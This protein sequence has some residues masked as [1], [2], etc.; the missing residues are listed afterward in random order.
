MSMAEVRPK[1]SVV[2]VGTTGVGRY[3]Q[4]SVISLASEAVEKALLDAAVSRSSIDGLISHIGYPRG[5]DYD[6]LATRLGLSVEFAAQPWSH[7]RFGASVLQHAAMA[8]A[9]GLATTV[10]C[11][12]AYRNTP[13]GTVGG[14]NHVYFAEAMR[15]GGGPHA[16]TPHAALNAPVA[17]C[18]MATQRYLHKYGIARE[19]LAA[20]PIAM[21]RHARLNSS[22]L[23]QKTLDET[24]YVAA[25]FIVEP[26]RLL[27]CSVVADGAVAIVLTGD[28]RAADAPH[29]MVRI[30]GMQG[31]A[32]GPNAYIFG[33]PG[34]GINDSK[35][36]DFAPP[37]QGDRV[38]RM[39]GVK[40][41]DIQMLQIYDAFS[42]LVPFTLE[43]F[44]FCAPGTAID[45]LQNGRIELG[46]E[47]PVNTSGGMLSEGH[48]NGWNQFVEILVQLRHAAGARQ[49]V[50]LELAQWATALGDS[51]IFGR[52]P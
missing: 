40:P 7:G 23:M 39:A 45:W 11:V 49:V 35:L 41:D 38:Y 10:L 18:A 6:L 42:P 16:E 14:R 21:R 43:R 4:R 8:I 28:E 20:V 50:D 33:Q 19:R 27:D 29:P 32:A 17:G 44:G 47:L 12:A 46:G 51:I 2:G 13:S 31:I 22:A 1:V 52:A 36:F 24:D 30:L 5:I 37:P 48:L 34:L 25:P 15:D 9:S 3:P 26:L